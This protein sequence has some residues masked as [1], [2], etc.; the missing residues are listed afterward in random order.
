VSAKILEFCGRRK[1]AV[2]VNVAPRMPLAFR[3]TFV[4]AMTITLVA[5]SLA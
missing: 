2:D 3:L 4:G 1:R 5:I